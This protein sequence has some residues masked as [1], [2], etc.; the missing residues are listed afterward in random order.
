MTTQNDIAIVTFQEARV[1]DERN[2]RAIAK[3]LTDLIENNN[4][5]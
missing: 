5:I 2:V 1:L 4:I 3:E